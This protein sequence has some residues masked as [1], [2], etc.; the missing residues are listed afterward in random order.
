MV[1]FGRVSPVQR[2]QPAPRP[3][4]KVVRMGT[5]GAKEPSSMPIVPPMVPS[6]T[7]VAQS[8]MRPAPSDCGALR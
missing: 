7:L 1:S 8:W 3:K 2:G 6:T 4:V 5:I